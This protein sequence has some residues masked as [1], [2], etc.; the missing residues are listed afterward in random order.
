MF[1]STYMVLVGSYAYSHGQLL[2]APYLFKITHALFRDN[3]PLFHGDDHVKVRDGFLSVRDH[4]EGTA[5]QLASDDFLDL[6]IGFKINIAR[7]LIH[8]DYPL[9]A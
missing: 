9:V 2:R 8:H 4:N 6:R 7:W 5:P 3:A 1:D